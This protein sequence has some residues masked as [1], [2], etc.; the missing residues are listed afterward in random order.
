[1]NHEQYLQQGKLQ[2]CLESIQN[3]ICAN[4]S[5]V[6]SRIFL[7]QLLA[8]LGSWDRAVRGPGKDPAE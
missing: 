8:V 3:E 2:D 5:D 7:F 6:K 4:S 1:M